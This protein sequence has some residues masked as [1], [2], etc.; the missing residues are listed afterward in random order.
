MRVYNVK[1]A[2]GVLLACI[3]CAPKVPALILT[4]EGN[5]PVRDSGWPDGSLAVANLPTRVG[6]WE[7][8]P[9]GGGEYHF[10][11]RGNAEQFKAMLGLFTNINAPRLEI[12]I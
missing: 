7:G 4:G 3:S 6:W 9:F 2:C 8:P 1:F 11:Y 5:V 10:D 12:V